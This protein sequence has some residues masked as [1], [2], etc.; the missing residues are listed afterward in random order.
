MYILFIILYIVIFIP[1]I[2]SIYRVGKN[3]N[4]KEQTLK[5]YK[6]IEQGSMVKI[7]TSHMESP[8]VTSKVFEVKKIVAIGNNKYAV[9]YDHTSRVL[10]RRNVDCL[11]KVE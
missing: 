6:N 5:S 1:T 3:K 9:L 2:I 7:N 10:I 11:I 8:S 4:N